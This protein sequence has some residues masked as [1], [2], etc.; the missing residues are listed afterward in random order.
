M[1]EQLSSLV[2]GTDDMTLHHCHVMPCHV[3]GDF[4]QS[5][6]PINQNQMILVSSNRISLSGSITLQITRM[7]Q[8]SQVLGSEYSASCANGCGVGLVSTVTWDPKGSRL[9]KPKTS[10]SRQRHC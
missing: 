5:A 8:R 9:R 4:D 3:I 1:I 7:D 2:I 6:L 10:K